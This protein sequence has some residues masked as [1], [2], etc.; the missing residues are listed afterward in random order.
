MKIIVHC[1][2]RDGW[3]VQSGAENLKTSLSPFIPVESLAVLRRLLRC[4]GENDEEMA[5]FEK[6]IAVWS[7]GSCWISDLTEIGAKLLKIDT[8]KMISLAPR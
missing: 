3:S 1:I 6:Q 5:E 8:R 4:A 7:H 2:H